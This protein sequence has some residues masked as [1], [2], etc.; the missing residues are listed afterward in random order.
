MLTET[1]VKTGLKKTFGRNS[2]LID[3]GTHTNVSYMVT[4]EKFF[5]AAFPSEH[6]FQGLPASLPLTKKS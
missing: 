5:P 3:A 4:G 1:K 6:H 2:K